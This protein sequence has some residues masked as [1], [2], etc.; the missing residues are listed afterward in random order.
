MS[1]INQNE[2]SSATNTAGVIASSTNTTAVVS[3][4]STG[5]PSRARNSN[6][7]RQQ[8]DEK[9]D[10]PNIKGKIPPKPKDEFYKDVQQFHEKRK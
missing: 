3:T 2:S 9:P 10:T 6:R 8:S 4:P 5:T 7:D 1:Q